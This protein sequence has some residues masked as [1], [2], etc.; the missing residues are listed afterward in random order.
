MRTHLIPKTTTRVEESTPPHVNEKIRRTTA[1][2]LESYID[3][4]EDRIRARLEQL[5]RE[6]D[7]ERTLETNAGTVVLASLALGRLVDRRWYAFPAVVGFFLINHAVKGWCPP[8]SLFR[9]LG[10]RTARE[11]E[12]ERR[13]L[14]NILRERLS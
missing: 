4:D 10:V 12:Q 1:R 9:R 3:A 6:W 11:I 8:V 7:V 14:L 13:E 5:D 2:R